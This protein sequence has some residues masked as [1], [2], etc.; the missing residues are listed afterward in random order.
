[1]KIL[2]MLILFTLMVVVPASAESI[3]LKSGQVVEGKIIEQNDAYIKVDRGIGVIITYYRDQIDGISGKVESPDS[4]A[5][6]NLIAEGEVMFYSSSGNI[7]SVTLKF[8]DESNMSFIVQES[9]IFEG[10]SS[11]KEMKI[12]DRATVKYSVLNNKNFAEHL[13]VVPG[14]SEV[15]SDNTTAK[16]EVIYI[17]DD[18]PTIVELKKKMGR[19]PKGIG[20]LKAANKG[21]IAQIKTYLAD[22]ADVNVLTGIPG[23]EN[24]PLGFAASNGNLEVVKV[25]VEGGA[26]VNK[27][28]LFKCPPLFHAVTNGHLEVVKY[29]IA[30]GANVNQPIPAELG[31]TILTQLGSKYPEIGQVLKAAGAK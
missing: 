9:T 11:F 8:A 13:K 22:G 24:T 18:D 6:G 2:G 27:L 25:L 23:M 10:R 21:D 5:A 7:G 4:P 19:D 12:F 28:A 1:M 29:L 31:G 16:H 20:L 30:K 14:D 15:N 17:G 26:D 3:K